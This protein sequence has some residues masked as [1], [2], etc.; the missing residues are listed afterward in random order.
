MTG[1]LRWST[2]R[3]SSYEQLKAGDV[4]T[5]IVKGIQLDRVKN[6]RAILR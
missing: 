3:K 5:H 1:R 2:A 4:Y 6:S